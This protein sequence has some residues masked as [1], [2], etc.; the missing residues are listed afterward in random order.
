MKQ[1]WISFFV[2]LVFIGCTSSGQNSVT[3][4]VYKPPKSVQQTPKSIPKAQKEQ[5]EQ[6]VFAYEEAMPT[7]GSIK[8]N[9]TELVF[10]EG[11]WHYEIKSRD[12]SNQK[13]S[14]AKFTH[15]KKVAKQGDFVYAIIKNGRLK[16]IYLIKKANYRAKPVKKT[17]KKI[18]QHKPKA[19]KRT[20]KQQVLDVPTVESI[21]LD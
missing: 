6:K 10:S 9:V 14:M 13:L 16:E 5:K 19:H 4:E 15:T 20:K 1:V 17:H 7:T 11:L 8:G 3:Y 2:V 21:S 18:K 12:T